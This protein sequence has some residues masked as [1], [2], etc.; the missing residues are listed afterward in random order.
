MNNKSKFYLLA[1]LIVNVVFHEVYGVLFPDFYPLPVLAPPFPL[2]SE[3]TVCKV[4][5]K[6][7]MDHQREIFFVLLPDQVSQIVL[8]VVGQ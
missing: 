1:D 4:G 3:K 5:M 7:R 2:E 8:N 6:E